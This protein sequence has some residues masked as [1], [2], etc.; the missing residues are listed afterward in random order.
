MFFSSNFKSKCAVNALFLKNIVK[1]AELFGVHHTPFRLPAD[2]AF[3]SRPSRNYQL[4]NFLCLSFYCN[5][6]TFDSYID[7]LQKYGTGRDE[8]LAPS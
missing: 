1:I 3:F 6:N 7:K 5:T 4:I 8:V 2:G